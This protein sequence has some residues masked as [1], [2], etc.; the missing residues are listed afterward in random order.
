MHKINYFIIT[1]YVNGKMTKKLFYKYSS[2]IKKVKEQSQ[3][4]NMKAKRKCR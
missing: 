4:E 2:K 3:S 1:Y